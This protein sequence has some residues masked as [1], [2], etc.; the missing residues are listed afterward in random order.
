LNI[1]DKPIINLE[2]TSV[3]VRAK[4]KK[5]LVLSCELY[6][7]FLNAESLAEHGVDVCQV[8]TEVRILDMSEAVLIEKVVLIQEVFTN[9]GSSSNSGSVY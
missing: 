6:L 8:Q 1:N 5:E 4:T 2:E 7:A 9:L 3:T